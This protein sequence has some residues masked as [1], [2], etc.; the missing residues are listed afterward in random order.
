MLH[1]FC[2]GVS[3][4]WF[5]FFDC[6][7]FK[8]IS[9]P[10]AFWWKGRGWTF[11]AMDDVFSHYKK[12]SWG[13]ILAL[14]ILRGFGCSKVEI[15]ILQGWRVFSIFFFFF[16]LLGGLVWVSGDC[17]SGVEPPLHHSPISIWVWER[18]CLRFHL[19]RRGS[20]KEQRR[21]VSSLGKKGGS[22]WHE[23]TTLT[24]KVA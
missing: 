1:I 12:G 8:C 15:S 7:G 5:S 20:V 19:T 22:R 21:R 18:E 14:G 10:L 13:L 3:Y 6:V 17:K 9:F 16:S 4:D 2:L 23:D 24:M 11:N